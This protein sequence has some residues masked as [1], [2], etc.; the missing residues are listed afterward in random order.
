VT[1]LLVVRHAVSV[2]PTPDGP[3]D[4]ERP[5]TEV[6][7]RQAEALTDALVSASPSRV[8]SSPYRRAVQTVAPTASALGLAVEK[9][10]ALREW[11]SGIGPTPEWEAHYR[12]CWE[13]PD[14]S[15]PGGETHRALQERAVRALLQVATE[16]PADAAAV[17]GSHGTWVARALHGLGCEVDAD[18]WLDMPMPAVF[19]VLLQGETVTVTGPG[20]AP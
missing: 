13:R 2:P 10:H 6:G 8:L 18:F 5:L 4:Y 16:G 3:D 14:W 9:R 7:L 19:E 17:V 15:L 20:V 11:D 12:D 1:R